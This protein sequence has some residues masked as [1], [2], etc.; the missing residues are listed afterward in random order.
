MTLLPLD[1]CARELDISVSTLRRWLAAGAPCA[2]RGCGRGITTL[3]DIDAVR[4][5]QSASD[6][7]QRWIRVASE[8]PEL[9]ADAID[10]AS[11]G[12]TNRPDK[13]SIAMGLELAY[14]ASTLAVL[15][16]LR[17][18]VPQIPSA[19]TIPASILR[20]RANAK[21]THETERVSRGGVWFDD[22]EFAEDER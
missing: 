16:R 8:L 21:P 17:V 13:R 11:R 18:E 1:R 9:V 22:H 20:L 14:F 3:I 15:R 4:A 19:Q 5:W 10:R 7:E 2:R 12:I 6:D